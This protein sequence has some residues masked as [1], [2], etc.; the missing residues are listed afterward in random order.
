M[1]ATQSAGE[2]RE[3]KRESPAAPSRVRVIAPSF[4]LLARSRA[5]AYVTPR[6]GERERP[7]FTTA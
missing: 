6:R 3:G 5:R 4:A 7:D 2:R 1:S